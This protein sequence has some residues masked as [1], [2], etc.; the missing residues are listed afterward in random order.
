MKK[1]GNCR[2][3]TK[4]RVTE[5]I[6]LSMKLT[7]V[8]LFVTVIQLSASVYSQNTKLSID[9]RNRTVKEVLQK[10][11]EQSEFRFFF[12]EKFIDLNRKV[13]VI[14]EKKNVVDILNEIF[15]GANISYKVMDNNLIVITPVEGN[16]ESK[17]TGK[18]TDATGSPLPGVSVVVKGTT[19][20]VITSPEG[21]YSIS[22]VPANSTLVFSFVGM[23]SQEIS[24]GGKKAINVVLTEDNVKVDEVVVTALGISRDKKALG[25]AMQSVSGQQIAE[26]K[27]L[28]IVNSL[29]G[30]VSGVSITQGNGKVGVNSR[31][32][33]RGETSLAGNNHPLVII[34]GVG[35]DIND[36]SAYDIESMSVLKGPAAAA[37]YG[38]S[39]GNGVIIIK[40]KEGL[41][42]GRLNVDVNSSLSISNPFILPDY[43][44]QYG[45]GANTNL[46]TSSDMESWGP[47]F[48]GQKI[49][50]IWGSDV[51][52]S[53]PNNAKDFYDTG[54]LS[55][56][57]VSIS[58]NN[59]TGMF[60]LSF[61]DVRQKGI[62]PNT[63]F[64]EN[65][66][67]FLSGWTFM[68][69]KVD[70]KSN[71]H[72]VGRNS[73]NEG[74][75]TDP[76]Y[77][78]TSLDLGTIKNYWL[79]DGVQQRK[80]V[81]TENNPYFDL[82][83][84]EDE[85]KSDAFKA[86]VTADLKLHRTLSLLLRSNG[87][88]NV[89]E[90]DNKRGV[91][92][93]GAG[94]QYGAYYTGLGKSYGL[95]ADW[96]LTYKNNFGNFSTVASAGGNMGSSHGSWINGG[97]SQ[98]L[99]PEIYN[100]G[101]HR[102][103]S[104]VGNENNLHS[105]ST[106]LYGL[107]NIGYKDMLYLDVTGRNDWSSTLKYKENDSYFYPSASTSLLLN[108]LLNLGSKVDLLKLKANYACVGKGTSAFQLDP[109]FVW[110]QGT[111][112][113]AGIEEE[114]VKYNPDL[115]P[116]FTYAYEFGAQTILFKNR[117]DIDV[118]YYTNRTVNQIWRM[119]V[120]Q[121][122]G[123]KQ[124]IR[125]IGEVKGQGVEVSINA[126]PISKPNFKWTTNLNWSWDRTEVSK[127][128]PKNPEYAITNYLDMFLYSYDAVG[129]RRGAIYSRTSRKF[130]FD[131]NIHDPSLKA[132]DGAVYL[133][134]NKKQVR[135][136]MQVVGN[137][138]PDWIASMT[139]QFQYKNLSVSFLL[140]ASVGGD[141]YN[142]FEK[143]FVKAGLDKRTIPG[144]DGSGIL[145]SGVWD[146]PGGV[147]PFQKG[148]EIASAKTYWV[149]SMTD[150]EINDEWIVDGSFLK[151]K[152]ASITY[153]LPKRMLAKTPIRNVKLSL[154]G[155]NLAVWTKVKYV[156]PEIY[157]TS[158]STPGYAS[159]T[160][161]PSTRLFSFNLSAS[162]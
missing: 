63:K 74:K 76:R 149:D 112:G 17:V 156:D 84:N 8:M 150:G 83:E 136:N 87:Y 79:V 158:S 41:K 43:Q 61:T 44:D 120:S 146:A 57:N 135:G 113:V 119:N 33:I 92:N 102:I 132:Y 5:K 129:K 35:G 115:K 56:N 98:L 128:D 151:L 71:V 94:S 69:G 54:S 110:T 138:N 34:D 117:L 89:S 27:E 125:N 96:L 78:P 12:N 47:K 40:T 30:K 26:S 68:D 93:E 105:K 46:Y 23:K 19:Q 101:N 141:Y 38:S 20:G 65:K 104:T 37:L 152:E 127:L 51:W 122:S 36:V 91:T 73:L 109:F 67:D 50:Q 28:D 86:Y 22:G 123:Y 24:V 99:L 4:M 116:E 134:A 155:R 75:R 52:K 81:N 21:A 108:K 107:V 3:R 142:C 62:I 162:F 95:S 48:E 124:V 121:I 153:S 154:V 72:Y 106:A 2:S 14:S 157:S 111:G 77:W 126:T 10:I 85:N 16:Q 145:P 31:I 118:T 114:S 13:S 1:N 130:K 42:N 131:P 100:L 70:I 159:R 140:T 90:S 25:Y 45:Q 58:G 60:R 82:Y 39:A 139:N 6:F 161:V 147:R 80:F 103:Y 59:E 9:M 15:K 53:N 97:S 143:F 66:L 32:I 18:V 55:T 29:A 133:D 160:D 7:L 88:Y 148:D 49:Q 137:Y 144:R 64:N 11:E